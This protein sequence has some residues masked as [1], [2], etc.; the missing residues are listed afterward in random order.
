[1]KFVCSIIN[2][3]VNPVTTVEEEDQPLIPPYF[4]E[5]PAP[6]VLIEVPY[7]PENE[8]HSKYFLRKLKS[9]IPLECTL[10]IKWITR[11]TRTL[12]SLKSKNLYPSCKIYLG[13]CSCGNSYIGETKRN[14]IIRWSEHN[15]PKG[16][17][18]PS[19]HLAQHPSHAFT[20]QV[21]L[22]APQ[23]IRQRKNLPWRHLW[24]P[25]TSQNPTIKFTPIN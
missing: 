22:T 19:K 18:K 4:F 16:K 20:W 21:L 15:D 14:T 11:K 25:Y 7:C 2:N 13:T 10:V 23:N 3:F 12:F 24:L 1:M 5:Q 8:R 6:F 17:S 9:F